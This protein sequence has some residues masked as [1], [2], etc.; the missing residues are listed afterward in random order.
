MILDQFQNIQKF[1]K[2]SSF[3]DNR[4]KHTV[5]KKNKVSFSLAAAFLSFLEVTFQGTH[6]HFFSNSKIHKFCVSCIFD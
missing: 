1:S 6:F 4:G 5:L 3:F 2:F